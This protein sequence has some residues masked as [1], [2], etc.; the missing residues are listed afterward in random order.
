[1][2]FR[3]RVPL[4]EIQQPPPMAVF[5]GVL[6]SR[7]VGSITVSGSF[8]A[9]VWTRRFDHGDLRGID[10]AKQLTTGLCRPRCRLAVPTHVLQC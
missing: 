2:I 8:V 3:V 1:M 5:D 7:R 9:S 6:G 10:G 4:T